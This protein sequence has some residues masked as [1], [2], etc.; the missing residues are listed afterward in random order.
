MKTSVTLRLDTE[1]LAATRR[2]AVLENRTL[3]NFIETLLK[4]RMATPGGGPSAPLSAETGPTVGAAAN[5]RVAEGRAPLP[6]SRR[7]SAD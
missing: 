7:Q 3:T 4:Q 1:L 2:C 6:R 5:G